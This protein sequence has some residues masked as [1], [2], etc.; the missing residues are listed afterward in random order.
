LQLLCFWQFVS[1][2]AFFVSPLFPK[3]LPKR[4][5]GSLAAQKKIMDSQTS[6]FKTGQA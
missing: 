5:P 6:A 3:Q 2:D 1:L 4:F